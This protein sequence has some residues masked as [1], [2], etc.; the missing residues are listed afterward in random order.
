M[1]LKTADQVAD[2]VFEDINGYRFKIRKADHIELITY[3]SAAAAA[4]LMLD[5]IA[6]GVIASLNAI[7]RMPD[8]PEAVPI[9]DAVRRHAYLAGYRDA[10]EAVRLRLPDEAEASE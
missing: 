6:S 10:M 2:K 9:D 3:H 8:R 4:Q 1:T 7:R 5:S